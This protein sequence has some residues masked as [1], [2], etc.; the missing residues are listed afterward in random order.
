MHARYF[1]I[2]VISLLMNIR[3][4]GKKCKGT[5]LRKGLIV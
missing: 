1:E 3:R 2:D 4:F 5:F